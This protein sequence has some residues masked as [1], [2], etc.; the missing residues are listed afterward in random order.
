MIKSLLSKFALLFCLSFIMTFTESYAQQTVFT[1]TLMLREL[2]RI[3]LSQRLDQL[4]P[5][6]GP[7]QEAETIL[8]QKLIRDF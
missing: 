4:E 2:H 1:E 5:Q 7:L 8:V 3:L 6:N